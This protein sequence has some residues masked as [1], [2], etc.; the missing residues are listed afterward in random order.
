MIYLS[1]QSVF[2][3]CLSFTSSLPLCL[4]PVP[5]FPYFFLSLFYKAVVGIVK[6]EAH[7]HRKVPSGHSQEH[8][9]GNKQVK[10]MGFP[11]CCSCSEAEHFINFQH[12][13]IPYFNH[14]V[15][16]LCCHTAPNPPVP[17]SCSHPLSSLLAEVH[18]PL[19]HSPHTQCPFHKPKS[20]CP[21]TS[22]L[23]K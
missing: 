1:F 21:T 8:L 22:L 2:G 12:K 15:N 4:L 20:R 6:L 11:H 14:R 17:S 13:F 10:A 5:Y 7:A 9:G 19:L 3:P 16:N 23:R 18:P